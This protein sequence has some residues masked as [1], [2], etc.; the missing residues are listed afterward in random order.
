MTNAHKVTTKH[1]LGLTAAPE[2]ALVDTD[3]GIRIVTAATV[4]AE[5]SRVRRCLLAGTDLADDAANAG[6]TPNA[7][8]RANGARIAAELNAV[9]ADHNL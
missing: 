5:G 1:L 3:D 2:K 9:L 4:L 7:Y 8:V 6:Q